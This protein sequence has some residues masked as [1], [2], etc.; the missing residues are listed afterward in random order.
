M[1]VKKALEEYSSLL[2]WA[3][4]AHQ[5][6]TAT[7]GERKQA[8][9]NE[10]NKRLG[11]GYKQSHLNNWAANPPRKRMPRRV[12]EWLAYDLIEN[13]IGFDDPEKSNSLLTLL[14]LK[15]DFNQTLH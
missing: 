11:T 14:Q 2:D 9:L 13:E 4:N 5:E 7:Q 15:P 1:N 10:I 8:L 3:I 12:W 6:G